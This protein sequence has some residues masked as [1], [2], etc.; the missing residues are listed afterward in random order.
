[1]RN[2]ALKQMIE[3]FFKLI[4]RS[5]DKRILVLDSGEM[6]KILHG[7]C[8]NINGELFFESVGT[9]PYDLVHLSTSK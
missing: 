5:D 4:A 1:M 3:A 6:T 7:N 9:I 2:F 8:R